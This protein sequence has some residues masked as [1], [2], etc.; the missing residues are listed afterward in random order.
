MKASHF[1]TLFQN[2]HKEARVQAGLAGVVPGIVYVAPAPRVTH[3]T[4]PHSTQSK[5]KHVRKKQ[6]LT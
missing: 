1:L 3:P 2:T 4:P 6:E 5:I